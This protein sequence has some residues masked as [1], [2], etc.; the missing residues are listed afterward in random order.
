MSLNEALQPAPKKIKYCKLSSEEYSKYLADN[1][2]IDIN[3]L[4]VLLN[5]K[6]FQIVKKTENKIKVIC[7]QCTKD[8]SILS[9]GM[10]STSNLLR[11]LRVSLLVAT[12]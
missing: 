1:V 5:G 6:Y 2:G 10:D 8:T 12:S 7:M 3:E 9:A 11:H 4:S